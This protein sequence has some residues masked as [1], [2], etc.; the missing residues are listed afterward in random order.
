MRLNCAMSGAW[1]VFPA[2]CCP[3][4]RVTSPNAALPT[5]FGDGHYVLYCDLL[6]DVTHRA[7]ATVWAYCLMP[8]HVH[9]IAVPSDEDGLRST[10]A[11][12]HRRA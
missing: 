8:N 5:F 7:G 12:A 3:V 9:V 4:I 1:L 6:A 10:F 11:D 2:L